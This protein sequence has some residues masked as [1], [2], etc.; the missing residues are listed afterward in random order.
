VQTKI[1]LGDKDIKLAYEL[2]ESTPLNIKIDQK[3]LKQ[4]L[5]N[6]LT[7][8]YKYTNKG[9]ISLKLSRNEE[10]ICFEISDTGIGLKTQLL[11]KLNKS[12]VEYSRENS[13][14]NIIKLGLFIVKKQI[15]LMNGSLEFIKNTFHGTT[16]K[17]DIPFQMPE[18]VRNDTIEKKTSCNKYYSYNNNDNDK[19]NLILNKKCQQPKKAITNSISF[20]NHGDLLALDV[21]LNGNCYRDGNKITT[22]TPRVSNKMID[23]YSFGLDSKENELML[24]SRQNNFQNNISY[25]IDNDN[26][27]DNNNNFKSLES[28]SSICIK[29]NNDNRF[30]FSSYANSPHPK[31]IRIK[32][33]TDKICCVSPYLIS[34]PLQPKKV[35]TLWNSRGH[36]LSL[37]QIN[38]KTSLF[39]SRSLLL[40]NNLTSQINNLFPSE[41]SNQDT[42]VLKDTRLNINYSK[43]SMTNIRDQI[44][45]GFCEKHSNEQKFFF[46]SSLNYTNIDNNDSFIYNLDENEAKSPKTKIYDD[47]ENNEDFTSYRNGISIK[48]EGDE[49]NLINLIESQN[50]KGVMRKSIINNLHEEVEIQSFFSGNRNK[51][52]DSIDSEQ[53]N[54]L[55]DN[56]YNNNPNRNSSLSKGFGEKPN[57]LMNLQNFNNENKDY[58]N[59]NYTNN[60]IS[61]NNNLDKEIEAATVSEANRIIESSDLIR[62]LV[63]DDERLIRKSGINV[64]TKFFKAKGKKICIEECSDGIECLFKLYESLKAGIRYNFVVTDESMDFLTGS[65]SA[66]IIKKLIGRNVLYD[67]KVFLHTSYEVELMSE[68]QRKFFDGVFTKPLSKSVMEK[69]EELLG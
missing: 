52:A 20:K 37:K 40:N 8:A 56:N 22:L 15:G 69:V 46:N 61:E 6:V 29:N 12:I 30:N 62:I 4:I 10:N 57:C 9:F 42:L 64:I 33:K 65:E 26:N 5:M 23:R 24:A 45:S 21:K 50:S 68:N 67:L 28:S 39:K 55:A 3:K 51:K 49:T 1:K 53:F 59:N 34:P 27:D 11:E 47:P 58:H 60:K 16:V 25:S 48:V 54:F 41:T 63:V 2:C 17:F 44:D 36:C 14:N 19:K 18:N 13:T 32:N 35:R 7:N 31:C 38:K 43:I 66:E